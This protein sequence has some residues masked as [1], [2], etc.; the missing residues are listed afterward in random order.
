MEKKFKFGPLKKR[1]KKEKASGEKTSIKLARFIIEKQNWIVS[2]FVAACLLSA[3]AMLFV[4]VNYDLTEYLPDNAQSGIGLNKMEDEFGYPGTAR[5]MLKDVTLYEAKQYKDRMENVDGV[6]QILWCDSTVNIYSGED[7]IHKED[8]EDYY[9]DGYA[10]MDVTFKEGNTAKSTS[11]AIDELKAIAGDKGCFTGMAVQNKSLQENL[12]SEMQLILTV[13][14]IMIFTILC[15]TTTAWS[16][17]FLFLLVMGVAIL[18]NRGTNI[19]I[20]RVSFLTNNVAMV[21]QLATSMDYSIFLLDA[22]TREKKKGLSDEEAMVNAVDAAINSIFASSLTTIAGFVALMFMKF[23]IGFDMGLVLAKGIVFSL[24]TVVFF[25]PAMIF[26]F[27]KWNEK[28]AHRSFLPDFHKMGR[29]IYKIRNIALVILIL[30]VPFAYT[31]QGM[32]SFLFGNS[33]VGVSEGTQVYADEQAINEKFGRSNMLVAIYPNTSAIT[34]KAMS[35]K[36]EDLEY[37][38]SVTS[39][40]NTLPEGV[41]EDFLPYSITSQLHTDTTSRMLIYIRTK[42][43]SDKA[44]EYTND[45]RDIVKKY[46]PEESYVVGETPSTEDI[47]TTITADN[48]RVNVLSLISVFV[49]VMFSFQSVLVPIIVMIPIEAAIYINM[50]VPYLVGETLVYMG[51]IIV[52][53]IQLGATVDYSILLTNNYMACRKTMKKKEA[54]VEALAMSCSSV[55]T[56][57]TILILAGYIVYMISSTAAI[58]GLGHLIGRGA[59]LSVCLVLTILPALLV[60]CD[61]IITS[62][63]MDRFKKYL[64]RRHEKRKALVK[65][66]IGA[67]K[68]KAS[69]ALARRGSQTAEVDGNEI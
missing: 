58:G 56:S 19:F 29:G 69:A 28:T 21:L 10:V 25:M 31:A 33:A 42:S 40:A 44:F 41:P 50:A 38:K 48:A 39:M 4:E 59:L 2:V 63:E 15:I 5:I 12:A 49:V 1:G 18:L 68:K 64:K 37:V 62:N 51:Y 26:R 35:D 66:G 13:A 46:Y 7:F 23:S 11:A 9:K 43:E 61:G 67:V 55:F 17:P 45:I 24:L 6:D 34:E 3:V 27:A 47:K 8:I 20:G 32:N 54:V 57:G 36:I 14:I 22:F 30:I 53:S 52:S 60:L 16:E 65:S